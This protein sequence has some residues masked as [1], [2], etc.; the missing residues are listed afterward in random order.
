M[1]TKLVAKFYRMKM[2]S[3]VRTFVEGLRVENLVEKQI[4]DCIYAGDGLVVTGIRKFPTSIR[5]VKDGK[6]VKV[7]VKSLRA[8]VDADIAFDTEHDREC[9]LA[10]FDRVLS[11]YLN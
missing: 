9:A 8:G 2:M 1:T 5:I 7:H 6:K 11:R 3:D 10:E 4:D